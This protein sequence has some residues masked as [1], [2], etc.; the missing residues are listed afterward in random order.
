MS[1][2]IKTWCEKVFQEDDGECYNVNCEY[3]II[4]NRGCECGLYHKRKIDRDFKD[5]YQRNIIDYELGVS[6]GTEDMEERIRKEIELF[7]YVGDDLKRMV[8]DSQCNRVFFVKHLNSL[9]KRTK[10][11]IKE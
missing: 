11:K 5:D 9:L 2:R 1:K 3:I 7:E 10:V 6:R 8:F 4:A